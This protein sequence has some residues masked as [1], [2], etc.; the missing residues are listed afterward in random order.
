M[1]GHWS[2]GCCFGWHIRVYPNMVWFTLESTQTSEAIWVK[3]HEVFF[4]VK[5]WLNF[6]ACSCSF[7][8]S[9]LLSWVFLLMVNASGLSA[10]L[11]TSLGPLGIFLFSMSLASINPSTSVS[12]P[13][14]HILP[15]MSVTLKL[16]ACDLLFMW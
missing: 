10:W 5:N 11:M 9:A 12:V 6:Y 1:D 4:T 15:S 14:R 16:K 2:A 3:A 8:W 7:G 13:L